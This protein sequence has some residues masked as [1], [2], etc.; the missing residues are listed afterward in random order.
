MFQRIL[1]A[2]E[3]KG[4]QCCRVNHDEF[5]SEICFKIEQCVAEILRF[6]NR[7]FRKFF[8]SRSWIRNEQ[9]IQ[10][11]INLYQK[12]FDKLLSHT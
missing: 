3:H 9:E 6:K 2:I 5:K 8:F 1:G 10:T 7:F 12:Q 4:K 11:K